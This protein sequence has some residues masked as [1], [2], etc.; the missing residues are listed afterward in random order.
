VIGN[1]VSN[2]LRHTRAGSAVTVRVRS[3]SDDRGRWATVEV[4]DEGP[5]LSP[6]DSER[7]FERFYRADNARSRDRGGSGLGL[8]IVA[9]LV[10]AHRGTVT[11]DSTQ[12]KG[13]TFTVRLPLRPAPHEAPATA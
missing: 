12:G 6:E 10:A 2:A 11:V 9:A 13:A 8:A 7:V 1:L 4:A 3:E 5:G